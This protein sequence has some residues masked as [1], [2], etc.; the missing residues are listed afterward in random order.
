MADLGLDSIIQRA[1][2]LI[3]PP[4]PE[5]ASAEIPHPGVLGEGLPDDWSADPRIPHGGPYG[6][7]AGADAEPEP[8][9]TEERGPELTPERLETVRRAREALLVARRAIRR[10]ER[11]ADTLRGDNVRLAK[12]NARLRAS[13]RKS[14]DLSVDS[15]VF[16]GG[17][18]GR[19]AIESYRG[20][21][22]KFIQV[23]NEVGPRAALYGTE[24]AA[25][26][27]R[28][29][30]K[31]DLEALWAAPAATFEEAAR[32]AD[33]EHKLTADEEVS[34]LAAADE[35]GERARQEFITAVAG[36]GIDTSTQEL[37]RRSAEI[38]RSP[39]GRGPDDD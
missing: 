35:T 11:A 2:D 25:H 21:A 29:P 6:E 22:G 4:K 26:F 9:Q 7:P 20:N 30:V 38:A 28:G 3:S 27:L 1:G 5:P 34:I 10:A 36:S 17:L 8:E 39:H 15:P 12:E 24:A 16:K 19:T 33:L 37:V 23:M 13:L 31:M 18:G 14:L 32:R